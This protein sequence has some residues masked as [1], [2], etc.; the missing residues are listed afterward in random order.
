MCELCVQNQ[1]C[2]TKVISGSLIL[3]LNFCF[4]KFRKFN[5]CQWFCLFVCCP[6]FRICTHSLRSFDLDH[7]LPYANCLVRPLHHLALSSLKYGLDQMFPLTK[8]LLGRRG[9]WVHSS[10]RGPWG[11]RQK[12]PNALAS[13]L[14]HLNLRWEALPHPSPEEQW[15]PVTEATGKSPPGCATGKCKQKAEFF[16]NYVTFIIETAIREAGIGSLVLLS[17]VLISVAASCSGISLNALGFKD[18]PL[19]CLGGYST[20]ILYL[21]AFLHLRLYVVLLHLL[22][23]DVYPSSITWGD[24]CFWSRPY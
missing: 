14:A 17:W 19:H 24:C 13:A 10:P 12:R 1:G 6:A 8:G 5:C 4:C 7:R 2:S 11:Q 20:A 23:H 15:M 9:E 22:W 21:L 3:I 16:W 18:D